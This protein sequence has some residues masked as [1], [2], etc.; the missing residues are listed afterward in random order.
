MQK[1]DIERAHGTNNRQPSQRHQI[2][3]NYNERS[4]YPNPTNKQLGND[5]TKTYLSTW[6][7]RFQ[8]N[9]DRRS[10]KVP[11]GMSATRRQ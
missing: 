4:R 2:Y 10:L 1:D 3:K 5:S 11:I 8:S 7:G 6:E 9:F